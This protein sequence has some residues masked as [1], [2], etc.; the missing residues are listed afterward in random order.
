MTALQI[1]TDVFHKH[2]NDV[3]ELEILGSAIP[4]PEGHMILEDGLCIGIPKKFLAAAFIEARQVFLRRKEDIVDEEVCTF[5]FFPSISF[6]KS[7]SV[8]HDRF[9]KCS[10]SKTLIMILVLR[11][12]SPPLKY[13]CFLIRSISLRRT[14]GNDIFF[15]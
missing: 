15:S 1:I 8:I 5:S 12:F 3:L 2:Q 4:L 13:C 14:V 7:N 11:M 10:N 6:L 9:S